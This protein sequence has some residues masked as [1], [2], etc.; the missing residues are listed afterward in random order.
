MSEAAGGGDKN[1]YLGESI[2]QFKLEFK[3]VLEHLRTTKRHET[4]ITPDMDIS[5]FDE[6]LMIAWVEF[7]GFIENLQK[8][9]IE[10]LDIPNLSA[11]A[12][13]SVKYIQALLQ[14]VAGTD[15]SSGKEG[16]K[17]FLAWLLNKW[18]PVVADLGMIKRAA[19]ENLAMEQDCLREDM[20]VIIN[21][22]LGWNF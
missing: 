3:R 5:A 14:E 16:K 4:N 18:T 7:K 8:T 19:P 2:E 11:Q 21:E 20:D 6:K 17:D 13:R 1:D 10:S 12:D 9:A 15:P 22:V